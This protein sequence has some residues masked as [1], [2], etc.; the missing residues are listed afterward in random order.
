MGH[1]RGTLP[2][3]I[4]QPD[5]TLWTPGDPLDMRPPRD[6]RRLPAWREYGYGYG[7]CC[8]GETCDYCDGSIPDQYTVTF[9]DVANGTCGDA[10]H[11]A[12]YWNYTFTLIRNQDTPINTCAWIYPGPESTDYDIEGDCDDGCGDHLNQVQLLWY[13]LAGKYGVYVIAS[14]ATVHCAGESAEFYVEWDEPVSCELDEQE[15]VLDVDNMGT[16]DFSAATCVVSS[17]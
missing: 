17:V 16:C 15:L 8:P 11:C 14:I 2:G 7:E 13:T 10:A 12:A 1:D 4:W 9:A 3:M 5:R 6:R